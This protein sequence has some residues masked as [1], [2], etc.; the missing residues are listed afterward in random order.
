MASVTFAGHKTSPIT[1]VVRLGGGGVA[2]GA[3]VLTDVNHKATPVPVSPQNGVS[4]SWTRN[5][6]SLASS[7]DALELNVGNDS[8]S[9]ATLTPYVKALQNGMPLPADAPQNSSGEVALPAIDFEKSITAGVA[10]ALV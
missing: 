3:F 10:L 4:A 8:P 6:A 7:V 2:S 5:E 1:I 9:G